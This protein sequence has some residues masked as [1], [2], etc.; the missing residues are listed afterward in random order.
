[1]NEILRTDEF[2]SGDV[3]QE[4]EPPGTST[5]SSVVAAM[6]AN[7]DMKTLR[8]LPTTWTTPIEAASPRGPNRGII[9]GVAANACKSAQP[10][11]GTLR[12]AL[13]REYCRV[14]RR[15]GSKLYGG[16][17]QVD[18]KTERKASGGETSSGL[19]PE[20]KSPGLTVMYL[21]LRS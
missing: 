18:R 12:R 2:D 5:D 16:R 8:L 3:Q 9:L 10:V 21:V 19:A 14:R 17:Y 13:C 6:P 4:G 7:V 15:T 1:M 20:A 11:K